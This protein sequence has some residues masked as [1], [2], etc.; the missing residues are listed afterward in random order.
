MFGERY[1]LWSCSLCHSLQPSFILH[2]S[3]TLF[4]WAST[5]T[6][7]VFFLLI[8]NQVSNPYNEQVRLCSC[9]SETG[10]GRLLLNDG[11]HFR[12]LWCSEFR[13]E[14]DFDVTLS[15]LNIWTWSQSLR[16]YPLCLYCGFC[17]A[18]LRLLSS[19]RTKSWVRRVAWNF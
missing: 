7:S 16:I 19:K 4:P 11:K 1:K 3:D 8:F 5:Q 15:F 12:D 13:H 10:S 9:T 14:C 17:C 6:P 2:L 18:V